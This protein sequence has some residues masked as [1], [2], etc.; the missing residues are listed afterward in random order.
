M[1]FCAELGIR[2]LSDAE[3]DLVCGGGDSVTMTPLGTSAPNGNPVYMVSC[4]QYEGVQGINFNQQIVQPIQ[5]STYQGYSCS[6][7][8]SVRTVI[9]YQYS[10]G[11]WFA[12]FV[13]NFSS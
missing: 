3:I 9:T 4:P 13:N 6:I 1:D 12:Q 11:G 10:G 5:N 2:E 7:A 8:S